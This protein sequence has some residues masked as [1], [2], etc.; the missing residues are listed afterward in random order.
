MALLYT[1]LFWFLFVT[2]LMSGGL[3]FFGKLSSIYRPDAY[4]IGPLSEL[5]VGTGTSPF[6][7]LSTFVFGIVYVGPLV[8]MLYA[9]LDGSA[10]SKRAA[11]LMPLVYHASSVVG[12]LFVFPHALNP[13]VAPLASAAAMHGVYAA[14]FA[15]LFWS[16]EDRA[17]P[18]KAS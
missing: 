17:A 10:S 3:G 1:C 4:L 2:T 12:V 15:L 11:S 5:T 9:H 13:A 16:A 7:E 6:E 8:G 18:L 14:L